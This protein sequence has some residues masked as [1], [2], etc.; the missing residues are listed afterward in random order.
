MRRRA[1]SVQINAALIGGA[2]TGSP[3]TAR[4][5]LVAIKSFSITAK[6]HVN[7]ADSVVA[8]STGLGRMLMTKVQ[9]QREVEFG[10]MMAIAD[11]LLAVGIITQDEHKKVGKALLKKYAPIVAGSAENPKIVT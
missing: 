4:F 9:L 2:K 5:A 7:T 11:R 10:G 1:N 6:Q 8:L 3:T